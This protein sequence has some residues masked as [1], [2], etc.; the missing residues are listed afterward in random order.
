M[1][2]FFEKNALPNRFAVDVCNTD[3]IAA[4]VSQAW[5]TATKCNEDKNVGKTRYV[6][7][8][9]ISYSL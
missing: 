6:A 8:V 3:F 9:N 2:S 5:V 4:S 7:F 1:Q